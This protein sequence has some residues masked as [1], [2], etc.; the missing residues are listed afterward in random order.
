MY[1]GVSGS[2]QSTGL[3]GS[4]DIILAQMRAS[5]RTRGIGHARAFQII[6]L[7]ALVW[8][9]MDTV[10]YVFL[11]IQSLARLGMLPWVPASHLCTLWLHVVHCSV[12]ALL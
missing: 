7:G 2:L 5:A 9:F 1:A 12:Q 8:G 11:A 6:F 3:E 10:K 4:S